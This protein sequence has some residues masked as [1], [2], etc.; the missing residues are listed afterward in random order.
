MRFGKNVLSQN[1][2]TKCDL[3]LHHTLSTTADRRRNNSPDPIK[4]RPFVE[5][6][7]QAG[8]AFE[9]GIY[10]Q[11]VRNLRGRCIAI[12][13]APGTEEWLD[14]PME[15]ALAT[16]RET[17]LPAL[18]LQPKM[19][20]AGLSQ[21]IYARLGVSAEHRRIMP[22]LEGLIPDVLLAVGA[23]PDAYEIMPDAERRKVAEDDARIGLCVIDVKHAR[24]P[25][26]SYSAEVVLYAV[27]LANW[28]EANGLRDRFLVRSETLLWTRGGMARGH[29][30]E[31]LDLDDPSAEDIIAAIWSDLEPINTAI[32]L[33]TIRRFFTEQMPAVIAKGS[34]RDMWRNLEWGVTSACGSCDWL[35]YPDFLSR[36]QEAK[37]EAAPHDY[38]HRRSREVDHLSRIPL[39][40]TGA[41]RVMGHANL[42]T[43]A[44]IAATDGTEPVYER[45]NR[46]QSER[47]AVPAYARAIT[48]GEP[49]I[50]G[51][52]RDG[53]L[54]RYAD[55]DVF[56]TVNF[57]VGSG[58]LSGIGAR[59]RFTQKRPYDPERAR[60]REA[61][62]ADE[63]PAPD[64]EAPGTPTTIRNG[65]WLTAGKSPEAERAML[66]GFLQFLAGTFEFAY[67]TA[68]DRGG[69]L[70]AKTGTQ[71]VFWSEREFEELCLAMGRHLPAILFNRD[72]SR[73]MKSLAWLFPPQEMQERDEI[74][75]TSPVVAFA[76]RTLRRLVRT[77]SEY[78]VT[79]FR[80]A[81]HYRY[82]REGAAAW[83]A[84][85]TFYAEPFADGIP[86]ERIYEIWRLT[87]EGG[88]GVA[89]WGRLDKTL[90]ELVEGYNA[91]LRKQASTLAD[92]VRRLRTDFGPRLRAQASPLVLSIPGWMQSVAPDS[93]LLAGWAGFE[94]AFARASAFSRFYMDPEEIEASY[95]GI[96]L[97]RLLRRTGDILEYEISPASANTKLRAPD[98]YLCVAIEAE[99][100]F[101]GLRIG[102]L[103][104]RD[105]TAAEHRNLRMHHIF[106]ATLVG[107][108]R[109]GRIA[110]IRPSDDPVHRA[111]RSLVFAKLGATHQTGLILM[112]GLGSD[113]R[114]ERLRRILQ[115]VGYP[116]IAAAAP[117]TAGALGTG[118]R[119]NRGTGPARP[120]ARVL[121]DAPAL[122][123]AQVRPDH[124]VTAIAAAADGLNP[125]QRNAVRHAAARA[126]TLL[127]G[128]PGTGKTQTATALVHGCVGYEASHPREQ[129]Y[130]ILLTGPNYKAVAEL[131]GRVVDVLAK[132][133]AAP[134]CG[135]VFVRDP[136][137]AADLCLP[138]GLPP[139]IRGENVAAKE[140][141]EG[142]IRFEADLGRPGVIVVA[143]V[144]HQCPRI[145]R[146]LGRIRDEGDDLVR[147][148]F[149]L[150]LVDESSQ[151]D[152]A[153]GVGPL[154]L[155]KETFQ[156]IV[157][158]DHLQMPPVFQVDPPVGA[159]HLVGSL[160]G[161][162]KTR[163][164]LA[165]QELLENYRSH[166]DIVAYT[167]RLGYPAEL[168]A[169]NGATSLHWLRTPESSVAEAIAEGG[170]AC[171][172][173]VELLDPGRAI[174]ALTYPDGM[175]GQ[176]NP[177]EAACVATLARA[178][179]LGT[180]GLLDGRPGA[181]T[182]APWTDAEFWELG[183]GVVTPHRAQRAQVLAA[184][185][186]AF[187][188]VD[189]ALIDGAV[190]TV[191]RFQGGQRHT[192]LISFGLGDP[193]L[194][195]GEER[196]LLQLQRTNVALSRAMAK[197]ILIMSEEMAG[198]LPADRKAAEGAHALR[199]IVDEWCNRSRLA[200]ATLPG[201]AVRQVRPRWRG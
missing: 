42:D 68:P 20:L 28:L 92:V 50:D 122:A 156:L 142:F 174:V 191:E 58:L 3:A 35:A 110:R 56:V 190:D 193:D 47:A 179:F 14:Q 167:K 85:D 168:T 54:A 26:P 89:K 75:P 124:E 88:A 4:S 32:Y 37:V 39:F 53:L 151:V 94:S 33:Q 121:W 138:E 43:V 55:L 44:R 67:S 2:R 136:G 178:L 5:S 63:A 176:A 172:G 22:T 98:E 17:D 86:R 48:A 183:L 78:A 66:L 108:D 161:Y 118:P 154:A 109:A 1:L 38:C 144:V 158:G 139:H 84:P 91:Q 175:A 82:E 15:A 188:D 150:V 197:C 187:P 64:P 41:R 165:R 186:R 52:R 105:A 10:R 111:L 36:E 18:V 60:R 19:E 137:R 25:N 155:L 7:Q 126:L 149:D 72:N 87:S 140:D 125:S 40:T 120:V 69:P 131:A 59:S 83:R 117:E 119:P 185:E 153:I 160:E 128:P 181:G 57:D 146:A 132:D 141:D 71:I 164:G 16:V 90:G 45:H 180:S 81:E 162:L 130:A 123:A 113:I 99:P 30:E 192:I 65:H 70:A 189:P 95:E 100:G 27:M 13:P 199:G 12:R 23:D 11:L 148:V 21:Q 24:D 198:H 6:L 145:G 76:Q 62:D 51:E 34:G 127:W 31:V 200:Q 182:H 163:F 143:T 93:K 147:P 194:I 106:Q 8:I 157:A 159:E 107:L 195:G 116:A 152:M 73:I 201:G 196:F 104:D 101:L 97:T 103:L 9:R 29:F 49:S 169:A 115:E 171:D 129:A 166:E 134:P 46:L 96:R 173:W 80:V 114:V 184:L 135:V 79:L 77:P 177:F 102:E 133:P 112:R 170:T 61:E 74:K